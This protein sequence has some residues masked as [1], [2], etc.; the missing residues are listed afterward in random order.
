M[1]LESYQQSTTLTDKI[2][3]NETFHSVRSDDVVWTE[4]GGKLPGLSTNQVCIG[5]ACDKSHTLCVFEG[6]GK[7]TQKSTYEAFKNN[8][9]VGA[10]FIHDKDNAHKK[11]VEKLQ[12][13]S[14][15]YDSKEM[16]ERWGISVR[17]V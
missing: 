3:F 5:V 15:A 17:Q 4:D 8:I 9:E 14:V 11:L 6:F 2:W 7:P 16:A 1:V 13:K 12:L 10:T